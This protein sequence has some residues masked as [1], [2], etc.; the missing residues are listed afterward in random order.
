MGSSY[1]KIRR[2]AINAMGLTIVAAPLAIA[3][4]MK[5][6]DPANFLTL[7]QD[8]NILTPSLNYLVVYCIPI[9]QLITGYMFLLPQT[10]TYGLRI[11]SVLYAAFCLW[12]LMPNTYKID[13]NHF[14]METLISIGLSKSSMLIYSFL[15]L[16]LTILLLKSTKAPIIRGGVAK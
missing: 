8:S 16:T 6:T 7:L 11:A 10:R 5:V 2:R 4:A 14:W 1:E 9:L 3:G 13:T 12:L 15:L